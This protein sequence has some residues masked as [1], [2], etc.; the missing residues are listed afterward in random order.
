MSL[1]EVE[2]ILEGLRVLVG[3]WSGPITCCWRSLYEPSRSRSHSRR[4]ESACWG[5][6]GSN[7]L[8]LEVKFDALEVISL[9]P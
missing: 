2:A 3:A 8:L 5:V 4:A 1:L 9:G 7:H 6:V